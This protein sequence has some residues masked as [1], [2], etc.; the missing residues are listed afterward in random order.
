[1]KAGNTRSGRR[2]V[3]YLPSH[4]PWAG[5]LLHAITTLRALAVPG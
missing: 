2:T 4:A 3:L 1:L 5:L